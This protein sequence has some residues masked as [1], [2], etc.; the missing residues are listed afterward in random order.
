MQ[1]RYWRTAGPHASRWKAEQGK[2]KQRQLLSCALTTRSC[3]DY[4]FPTLP[5]PMHKEGATAVLKQP[6]KAPPLILSPAP[7]SCTTEPVPQP[8]GGAH[9]L[10]LAPA[11]PPC[12]T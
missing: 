6:D 8:L 4:W 12:E 2:W 9:L 7:I 1:Q 11:Q 3:V 5:R 10:D